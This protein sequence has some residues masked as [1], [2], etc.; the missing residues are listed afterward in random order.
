MLP[1]IE[2]SIGSSAR[3]VL[4]QNKLTSAKKLP[5]TG[6]EP[7]TLGLWCSFLVFTVSHLPNWAILTSVNWIIFNSI[8]LVFSQKRPLWS[9]AWCLVF[10]S[11]SKNC[12]LRGRVC[13][14]YRWFGVCS[15][16][17]CLYNLMSV[18]FGVCT[19]YPPPNCTGKLGSVVQFGVC[20]IW[21]LYNLPTPPP[22][23]T[24]DLG[25]VWF[26]VC[27]VKYLVCPSTLTLILWNQ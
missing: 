27:M 1:P 3:I 25:S 12:D 14:L 2:L 9:K 16:I 21:C 15:L 24:D 22:N 23:R 8:L 19:I 13:K 7:A 11:L 10:E 17:W 5:L 4:E 6:I 20:T 18:W 26:G